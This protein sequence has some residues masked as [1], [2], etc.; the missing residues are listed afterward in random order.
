MT[1][2]INLEFSLTATNTLELLYLVLHLPPFC[3]KLPTTITVDGFDEY[4]GTSD[5][6]NKWASN[7]RYDVMAEWNDD[8]QGKCNKGWLTY[9]RKAGSIRISISNYELTDA[10]SVIEMIASLPWT[11]A[12]F[13]RFYKKWRDESGNKYV[14]PGFGDGNFQHGWACAF[15]GEGHNRLVSRR[16]LEYNPWHLIRDEA[17]DISFVQFHELDADPATALEQAKIGHQRM[18]ISNTGGYIKSQ[19]Y[20]TYQH[21]IRGVYIDEERKLDVVVIDR[22]V[23]QREMLDF[24]A[25]KKYQ[26][27]PEN[28]P[29]ERVAYVFAIQEEAAPYLHELWLRGLECWVYTPQGILTRIDEDYQPVYTPPEW[30]RRLESV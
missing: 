3:K 19:K 27:L 22:E 29:L 7:C 28:Q 13:P 8:V 14:P 5:W 17:H 16:W 21:E 9:D 10:Q 12:A 25:A 20:Y 2:K 30:V 4:S 11:L 6:V 23:S 15:K 18:G 26:I 24:C 1:Q